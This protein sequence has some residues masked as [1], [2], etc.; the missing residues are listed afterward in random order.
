M[1]NVGPPV[2]ICDTR[3]DGA[4]RATVVARTEKVERPVINLVIAFGGVYTRIVLT[5][6]Q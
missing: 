4:I 2:A 1:A 3:V 6:S 5:M